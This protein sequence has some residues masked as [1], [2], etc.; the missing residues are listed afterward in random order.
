MKTIL[1]ATV[2]GLVACAATAAVTQADLNKFVPG[3][4]INTLTKSQLNLIELA[5]HSGDKRSEQVNKIR[6]IVNQ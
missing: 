1:T 5:M 4:D 6:S 3:V 2:F